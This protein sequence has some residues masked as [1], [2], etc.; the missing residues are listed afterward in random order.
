M[1]EVLFALAA[2]SRSAGI[3]LLAVTV[4]KN[5]RWARRPRFVELR[6]PR[7]LWSLFLDVIDGV[8]TT[9]NKTRA[10][11][12]SRTARPSVVPRF[13]CGHTPHTAHSHTFGFAQSRAEISEMFEKECG[14]ADEQTT[15]FTTFHVEHPQ[16]Y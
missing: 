12:S 2:A 7:E 9:T 5:G 14:C 1:F 6:R 13:I 11:G 16:R 3:R 15:P 4:A 10:S 8:Q